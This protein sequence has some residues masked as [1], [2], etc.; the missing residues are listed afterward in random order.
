MFLAGVLRHPDAYWSLNEVSLDHEDFLGVETRKVMKAIGVVV[1]EKK[2]PELPFI[3][4]ELSGSNSAL[5]V[6]YIQRLM[7]TPCTVAQAIEYSRTIKGLATSRHLTSA[8]AAI[9]ELAREHRADSETA[10]SEAESLLRKVRATMPVP[11]RSPD[12]SDIMRRLRQG[13]PKTFIPIEFSPTLQELSGGLQPGHLW[14]IGGF[15]STGKSAVAV[16]FLLD[17]LRAGKSAMVIS[18]EMTQ[19]Q[20][21]IRLLSALSMVPQRSI[22]DRLPSTLE[23]SAALK[24]AEQGLERSNLKVY[25][26]VYKIQDVRSHA[27]RMSETVGCDVVVIDFIQLLRA[28]AGDFSF[29][30]MTEIILDLQQMAKDLRC[31]VVA[32]S[33][34]SNEMAKWESQGGDDN[35]YAFKGSGAIKDA[36]DFAI[37]LKRDRVRSSPTLDMH[38]MKNRHGEMRVIPTHMDLPTGRITEIEG[39]FDGDD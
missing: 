19:E 3:L 20:Y 27:Q 28:S 10:I 16:N 30:D 38:V 18:P 11:E 17:V 32:F 8:G 2:V 24:R 26:Y 39:G 35:F 21:I 25:D 33:Q 1:S 9:I 23:E 15:S 13:G 12:P 36:A 6:E 37:M 29:G 4:E 14:V 5:T 7:A 31:T 34:V 22:R